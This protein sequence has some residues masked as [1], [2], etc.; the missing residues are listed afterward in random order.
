MGMET[1]QFNIMEWQNEKEGKEKED[2]K[3]G[4]RGK[5]YDLSEVR[6]SLE[7]RQLGVQPVDVLKVVKLQDAHLGIYTETNTSRN[8]YFTQA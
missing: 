4:K 2:Y 5:N 1:R 8:L 3:E 7:D 6:S